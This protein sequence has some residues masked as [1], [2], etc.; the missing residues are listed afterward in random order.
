LILVTEEPI[1]SDKLFRYTISNSLY[2]NYFAKFQKNDVDKMLKIFKFPH[3]LMSFF[4]LEE[5]DEFC[6]VSALCIQ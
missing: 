2:R 6:R 5:R 3:R 4:P 1:V